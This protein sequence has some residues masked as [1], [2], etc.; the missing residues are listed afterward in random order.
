MMQI[1]GIDITEEKDN[2][3]VHLNRKEKEMIGQIICFVVTLACIVVILIVGATFAF[4][5]TPPG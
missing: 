1:R 5:E 4:T 2:M 3:R